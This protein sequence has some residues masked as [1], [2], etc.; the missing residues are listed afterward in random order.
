MSGG[1]PVI[2]TVGSAALILAAVAGS[3]RAQSGGDIPLDTFR[4]A[5]DSR[6]YLTVN[7][8][9]VLGHKEL[10]FGLGSLEWGYKM[11]GF[12]D[13]DACDSTSGGACY[14]IKN[15]VTAT[16]IGAF[17]LKAGPAELE[18]GVSV[19]FV[20]MDGDRDPNSLGAD[21]NSGNDDQEFKL[22]GQGIGSIGLHFK[23]RFIK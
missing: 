20:I 8:S 16:L 21:P 22:S 4:P 6:G 12:G 14:Q 13:E 5:M 7:A 10:S 18:F 11:L 9:Q 15:M 1:L 19:P 2:R 23:T 17:G 3:A